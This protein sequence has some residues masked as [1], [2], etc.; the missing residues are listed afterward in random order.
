MTITY[1][2]HI[3]A[4]NDALYDL[5]VAE[6]TAINVHYSRDFDSAK[7]AK[8]G[9]YIRFFY[10]ADTFEGRTTDGELREFEYIISYYFD[11]HKFKKRA[12]FEDLITSR[13]DRLMKLICDDPTYIVSSATVWF[14]ANMDREFIEM[15]DEEDNKT[16]IVEMRHELRF[17]RGLTW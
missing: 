14:N 6:F 4:V 3:K 11:Q 16:N 2:E 17:T 12:E 5:I 10:E 8:N 15:L 13:S 9:E 7:L 1:T